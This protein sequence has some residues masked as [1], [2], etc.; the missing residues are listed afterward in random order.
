MPIDGV[1]RTPPHVHGDDT[2]FDSTPLGSTKKNAAVLA[3]KVL[4][5]MKALSAIEKG[6]GNTPNTTSL[7]A[8]RLKPSG[9]RSTLLNEGEEGRGNTPYTTT[10]PNMPDD[11]RSP[12]GLESHFHGPTSPSMAQEM[13]KKGSKVSLK[14]VSPLESRETH[15]ELQDSISSKDL[16]IAIKPLDPE[17]I[18]PLDLSEPSNTLSP[19]EQLFATIYEIVNDTSFTLR[20]GCVYH[21]IIVLLV[22]LSCLNQMVETLPEVYTSMR[23]SYTTSHHFIICIVCEIFFLIDLIV[24]YIVDPARRAFVMTVQHFEYLLALLPFLMEVSYMIG[25][26]SAEVNNV[27]VLSDLRAIRMVRL[28]RLVHYSPDYT[29]FCLMLYLSRGVLGLGVCVLFL[30]TVVGGSLQYYVENAESTFERNQTQWVYSNVVGERRRA[31]LQSIFDS[32]Y[33]AVATLC[34]AGYGD[35]APESLGGKIS[36]S[37]LIIVSVLLLT[38][39][40]SVMCYYSTFCMIRSHSVPLHNYLKH[41]KEVMEMLAIGEKVRRPGAEESDL[42]LCSLL[43]NTVDIGSDPEQSSVAR[44]MVDYVLERLLWSYHAAENEDISPTSKGRRLARSTT[45]LLTVTAE[46]LDNATSKSGSQ[47]I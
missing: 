15:P 35:I 13:Q 25:K 14:S 1:G 40:T 44:G 8:I 19:K 24:R 29:N 18:N 46:R 10:T 17:A 7:S 23:D 33:W 6:R 37:L 43:Q 2:F 47:N 36:S 9:S 28:W 5:Q 22:L 20:P 11:Q 41:H 42:L 38:I 3:R 27:S 45:R 34:T 16:S 21:F 30:L 12:L 26:M 39:P 4:L 31:P 32:M